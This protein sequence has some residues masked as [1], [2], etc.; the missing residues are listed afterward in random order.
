VEEL[1]AKKIVIIDDEHDVVNIIKATLKSK[2]YI[3]FAAYNGEDGLKLIKQE[4]PDLIIVDL[5]MPVMSGMEVCKRIRKEPKY[6]NLPIIVTSAIGKDSGKSEEFWKNGL[7]CDDFIS[8]PFDPLDL[9]GRVEF[10]FRRGEY[11]STKEGATEAPDSAKQSPSD[12]SNATP[13]QVVKT[14]IEAWNEQDFATEYNCLAQEM[15]GNIS[16][17][18]YMTRRKQFY[19]DSEGKRRSQK[20]V[21]V[22]E[23]TQSHNAAKVVC[24]R[25][26]T[27]D[28]LSKQKQETYVLRKTDSG[29]KII[30]VRSKP[31]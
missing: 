25:E 1:T 18:D 31:A 17:K 29:W 15:Q 13:K 26:D 14:F 20:L 19:L 27:L 4:N 30:S 6:S 3:T 5:R 10:I 23:T 28:S 9:L 11:I 22:L 24:V 8:K 7:K 12:L 16:L 2:G 21:K